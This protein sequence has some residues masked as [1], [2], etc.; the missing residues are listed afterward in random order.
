MREPPQQAAFAPESLVPGAPEQ[1]HVQE[2]ERGTP[3]E[4]A[5]AATR[6]PDRPHAALTDQCFEGVG[7]NGLARERHIFTHW[8]GVVFEKAFSLE[9]LVLIEQ[10]ADVRGEPRILLAQPREPRHPFLGG[11]LDRIIEVRADE[12]P[13]VLVERDHASAVWSE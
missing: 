7:A 2:L 3:L 6:A 8:R 4:P 1:G 5:V 12:L 11:H 9:R 13:T 10:R